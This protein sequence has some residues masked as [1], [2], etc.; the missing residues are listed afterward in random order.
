MV[1]AQALD[2]LAHDPDLTAAVHLLLAGRRWVPACRRSRPGQ[3][4]L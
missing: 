1:G 2:D 4:V 3:G